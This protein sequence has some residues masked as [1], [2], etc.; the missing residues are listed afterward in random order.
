MSLNCG[1]VG[2]P[3][4]GKSTLFNALTAAKAA[5]VAN[6]PFCTIDPN[7]GI[8]QV[9]DA[10]LAALSALYRPKKTTPATVEFV[11]IAGLVK[12]ASQ[13]EGLG[14]KFL[15]HIREV[16]AIVHVVRCFEDPDVVHVA[17][18]VDPD[19]DV[20]IINTELILADLETAERRKQTAE[21]R[22]KTSDKAAR[23]EAELMA[24]VVKHLGE[25]KPARTFP[26]TDEDAPILKDLRLLT[27][28]PL[29]YAAN[30]AETDVAAETAGEP[31]HSLV[32]DLR[33]LARAEGAPLV[34]ISGKVEEEIAALP[35]ADRPEFLAGLGLKESGLDR[36][37]HAAYN[38]LGL[39]TFFTAGDD[40]C[41]AWTVTAGTKAPA[42]AGKIH[43]DI[44]K[45]FIRAEVMSC[46]DLLTLK[47]TAAVKEKGLLRLEGKEYVVKDGDVIYFRFNV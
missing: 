4:V 39:I 19:R 27:G 16:D 23:H 26:A 43:S 5:A 18:K 36:L 37:A 8:V 28:K 30:V 33:R 11:D 6:Y 24:R 13:G 22:T 41:R 9:P 46:D 31:A 44:E 20:E 32:A 2:L 47:S 45:G 29:L 40:E 1:I 35:E 34:V 42:A 10:R 21:K 38:L 7:V 14:N 15:S 3:N 17:G 12:G 25:G